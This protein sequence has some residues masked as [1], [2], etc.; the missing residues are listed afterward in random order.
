MG[1][2]RSL[3]RLALYI[4]IL[5]SGCA[6]LIY[7]LIWAR[8][9]HLVFGVSSLAVATVVAVF[10]LGIAIGSW[11]F[12]MYAE[13]SKDV[14]T[15]YAYLELAIAL[16]STFTFLLLTR[17]ELVESLY[18]SLYNNTSFF[19]LSLGRLVIAS[20]ILLP[21]TIC[22]GGTIPLVTKYLVRKD[23][24]LGAD[25]SK[26][27]YMNTLGALIGVLATGFLLVRYLGLTK[28]FYLA[29]L[30]NL[31]VVLCIFLF[32]RKEKASR[33]TRTHKAASGMRSML[34]ILFMTGFIALAFEVVLI[35]LYSIYSQ[36]TTYS[37]TIILAGFLAGIALGSYLISEFVDTFKRP[38]AHFLT[39]LTLAALVGSLLPTIMT[40][41]VGRS[42]VGELVAGYLAALAFATLL[43]L[44]FPLGVR[45]YAGSTKH[46]GIK[47]G[48]VYFMNTLGAVLGSLAAGFFFIPFLGMRN[49]VGVLALL[50][51]LISGALLLQHPS[52]KL[53]I[54]YLGVVLVTGLILSVSPA[55]YYHS[56]DASDELIFYAEGLS[57]TVS[58]V[59][60]ADRGETY[61]ELAVDSDAVAGNNPTMTID[62]K[63][64]AHLPVLLHPDPQRAAT[65]GYGSG[66][67]SYSMLLHD[68]DVYG[69]EIEHEVIAASEYFPGLSKGVL[70]HER[71]HLVVDDARNYLHATETAFD[72]IVTDVTN[73]KYKSN[74]SLYTV[75]YFEIMQERLT[76]DGIAAAWVPLGGLSY[77]DLRILIA[78]FHEVYEHTTVWFYSEG[79]THFV[80]FIGTPE[81]LIVDIDDIEERMP[82]LQEDLDTLSIGEAGELASMLLLGEEDV[83]RI[84]EGVPLHTDEHPVLE[85]SDISQYRMVAPL[86]NL[87]LL[88]AQQDEDLSLYYLAE[89]QEEMGERLEHILGLHTGAIR[90]F[91]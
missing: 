4:V 73:L 27:Y 33:D 30:L 1:D 58:V 3:S 75:D 87:K 67:T 10:M 16:T 38:L 41:I 62:S 34:P 14:L 59:A 68:V 57:G 44:L 83:A 24:A 9:L 26:I 89:H 66:G 11:L 72:V 91:T 61:R 20:I 21:P 69:L 23:Q 2:V 46:I 35:R 90:G 39:Y 49:T 82:P 43:G 54:P 88:L 8:S 42:L 13:K 7:E 22:I 53:V 76:E 12:G 31:L 45:L 37:F 86:T 15:A 79:F 74:P 84:S 19:L 32:S 52:K 5:L 60:Y 65:V 71:F 51:F 85:Y 50:S 47:T 56:E 64:L 17:F 77:N 63:L 48:K 25:F 70:E 78:S 28:S 29:V 55:H 81:R 36:A 18:Y 80:I 40:R 6:A